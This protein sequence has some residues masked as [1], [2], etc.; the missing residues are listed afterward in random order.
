MSSAT[1]QNQVLGEGIGMRWLS[2]PLALLTAAESQTVLVAV[3]S[4]EHRLL[5]YFCGKEA[6]TLKKSLSDAADFQ[7]IFLR[8]DFS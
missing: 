8:F 7:V 4:T 2:A 6:A 5:N 3:I 1:W